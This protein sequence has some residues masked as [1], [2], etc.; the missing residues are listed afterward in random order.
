MSTD[1]QTETQWEDYQVWYQEYIDR[2]NELEKEERECAKDAE[3]RKYKKLLEKRLRQCTKEMTKISKELYRKGYDVNKYI[4]LLSGQD[5]EQDKCQKWKIDCDASLENEK[6]K[7]QKIAASIIEEAEADEADDD[8]EEVHVL[9]N[10]KGDQPYDQKTDTLCLFTEKDDKSG[11]ES[12]SQIIQT[13]TLKLGEIRIS[14]AIISSLKPHQQHALKFILR[15]VRCMLAHAMGLGKTWTLIALVNALFNAGTHKKI[16]VSCPISALASWFS[17]LEK[18]EHL[19]SIPYYDPVNGENYSSVRRWKEHGG[20]LFMGHDRFRIFQLSSEKI[21]PDALIVDEAHQLLKNKTLFYDAIVNTKCTYLILAT[22]TPLQNHITEYYKMIKLIRP[23][24]WMGLSEQK[25]KQDFAKPIDKG[26]LSCATEDEIS[27][28]RQLIDVISSLT[29]QVVHRR[30]AS[31]LTKSLPKLCEYKCTYDIPAISQFD[32]NGNKLTSFQ[33][34]GATMTAAYDNKISIAGQFLKGIL[35]MGESAIVFSQ[36]VNVIQALK[37]SI[38]GFMLTSDMSPSDRYNEINAFHDEKSPSVIYLT[39][40]IGGV[41]LTL[42]K[43]TRVLLLEPSWNPMTDQQAICRAWR[44]GQTKP[45]TAYRMIANE[46]TVNLEQHQYNIGLQKSLC[47][48]RIIDRHDVERLFDI[49]Q[50]QHM[51]PTLLNLSNVKGID[52][53]VDDKFLVRHS[54]LFRACSRHDTLYSFDGQESLTAQEKAD[55]ENHYNQILYENDQRRMYK[56]K[57]DAD[58]KMVTINTNSPYYYDD[59]IT[60]DQKMIVPPM[61]PVYSNI[62]KGIV[63]LIPIKPYC[64]DFKYKVEVLDL[65]NGKITELT[66]KKIGYDHSTG[67][68]YHTNFKARYIAKF[69]DVSVSSEWS[70]EFLCVVK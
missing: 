43:A 24:V 69:G 37:Q 6:A 2:S 29:K 22:G 60:I 25:F 36:R 26:A 18:W 15:E 39:I 57:D 50:L 62:S 47:A 4:A 48:G 66:L 16:V 28:A 19:I 61:P 8:L 21:E 38:P 7:R 1:Q 12:A 56:L 70:A 13:G 3:S 35:E 31:I 45:V 58:E 52:D 40:Q 9:T 34:T 17:E 20:I 55:A 30:G 46:P 5:T 41:G 49:D 32:E 44:L 63:T 59:T 14:P 54:K 64:E 23:T 67:W 10:E 27:K 68:F 11:K 65:A 53:N 51:S 33:L 42:T